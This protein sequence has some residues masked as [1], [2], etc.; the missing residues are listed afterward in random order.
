[1]R[2]IIPSRAGGPDV[3]TLVDRDMPKPGRNQ[4]L[5][6]VAA[7]GVN[8]HDLNQRSR[9][10]GPAGSTDILGLEVSGHIAEVGAG[11]DETL[12]DRSVAALVDGGGYA[13][14]VI[15]D[16]DLV[17]DWSDGLSAIEAAAL[18]EALF[19]LQLNLVGLGQ[20]QPDEWLLIHGGTSGI[21]MAGIPFA[22][23]MGA[24]VVVTAGS[25][26]KCARSL[27]RGAMAAINYRTQDFVEE[28]QKL[29]GGRGVDVILDTVGGLYARKN[30][31]ALAMDGRL[32][33]L[34]P[35]APEFSAPLNEIMSK[36]A[37]VTGALLRAYPLE[38]KAILA[39]ALRR[40]MWPH[41]TKSLR[42]V[43]D[44]IYNLETV[45]DAHRRM[46][47]GVHVGKVMLGMDEA[48]N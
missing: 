7:A 14:Y 20:L 30:L 36:R 10:H 2:A 5:I 39:E 40:Q 22:K 23:L 17:F 31:A 19:T 15:A 11:V 42:P 41:A 32:L 29:T 27:E 34:S 48:A 12:L 24:K 28:V 47:E 44:R 13:E 21:G 37:R 35:A 16:V 26:E 1:M 6:R 45:Q 33:H 43:I 25:E 46:D 38:K 4:V 3:L 9:G 8:R 18:P